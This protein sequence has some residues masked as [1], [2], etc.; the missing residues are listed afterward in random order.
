MRG[1]LFGIRILF[2]GGNKLR[3]IMNLYHLNCLS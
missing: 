1:E 2:P 3:M